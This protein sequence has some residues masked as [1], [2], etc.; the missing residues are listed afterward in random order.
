MAGPSPSPEPK[1][2]LTIITSDFQEFT[3]ESSNPRPQ[4]T[5]AQNAHIAV[6]AI[7]AVLGL[8]IMATSADALRVF[9]STHLGSEFHLPVWPQSFDLAP[10]IAGVACGVTIFVMNCVALV[11]QI[12]PALKRN[13]LSLPALVPLSI[14]FIAAVISTAIPFNALGFS[15]RWSVQSWSCQW[16]NISTSTAPH[17]GSLCTESRAASILSVCVVPLDGLVVASIL[18]SMV[19]KGQRTGGEKAGSWERKGSQGNMS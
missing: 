7:S 4:S 14:A 5:I 9:H 11:G 16:S 1:Q 3:P 13:P 19:M 6:T 8:V 15:T 18:A 17:W 10:T 2:P 12:V